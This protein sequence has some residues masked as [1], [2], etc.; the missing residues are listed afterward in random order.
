MVV[1]CAFA[2]AIQLER[3]LLYLRSSVKMAKGCPKS[4][5]HRPPWPGLTQAPL[6]VR[7][8]RL[9]AL[10]L[11]APRLWTRRHAPPQLPPIGPQCHHEA[12]LYG[13]LEPSPPATLW[14]PAAEWACVQFWRSCRAVRLFGFRNFCALCCLPQTPSVCSK[15]YQGVI[16]CGLNCRSQGYRSAAGPPTT[17]G[18]ISRRTVFL[19]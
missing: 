14:F 15:V 10:A 11:S 8:D 13:C 7:Q 16:F 17:F 9:F 12:G 18:F 3:K 6:L 4:Q 1:Y 19:L 2:G 5:H